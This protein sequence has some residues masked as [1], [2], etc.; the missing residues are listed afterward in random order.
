MSRKSTRRALSNTTPPT[1]TLALAPAPQAV[2]P[3]RPVVIERP[4]LSSS[5]GKALQPV[6]PARITSMLR[7]LDLGYFDDFADIVEQAH[8]DAIFRR[9]SYVRRAAVAARPY[10]VSP[11][12]DVAPE[13]RGAAD[14]L[15]GMTR[16]M[17]ANVDQLQAR[18]MEILEAIGHGVDVHE[19]TYERKHGLTLP[20]L[21]EKSHVATRDL[22]ID[23][24]WIWRARDAK[25]QWHTIDGGT[26]CTA[27]HADKT[28][29]GKPH[30]DTFLV[31]RPSMQG[32]K[33]QFGGEYLAALWPWL[34]KLKG[35]TFWLSGAERFGNPL[36]IL[37]AAKDTSQSQAD[38]LLADL[39][40][41]TADSV[42]VLKGETTLTIHSPQ[43][44]GSTTVFQ[45][46]IDNADRQVLI[47]M[48]VPP[49][50]VIASV[51]GSRSALDTRDG[52]RTEGSK[53]DDAAMW[54][55]WVRGPVT[56]LRRYNMRREDVPLPVIASQFD[57]A[58]P[59]PADILATGIVKRNQ[60]LASAGLPALGDDEGGDRFYVPNI[61][62]TPALPGAGY[63]PNA[64]P[65]GVKVAD[66]AMNGA[67]G[68]TLTDIVI[69]VAAGVLP[70]DAGI[71][72]MMTIF[73]ISLEEATR[74]MG[75][76]GAGFVPA[77]PA[78]GTP[79]IAPATPPPSAAP[80]APAPIATSAP[81]AGSA[82]AASP[83]PPSTPSAGGMP[84]LLS[85]R[86]PTS[87]TSSLSPTSP[88]RFARVPSSGG[89]TS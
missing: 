61:I 51:N 49:D 59:I 76:A 22:W 43:A 50:L 87:P 73:Q 10:T 80:I 42:G 30:T 62:T 23:R 40:Q 4:P 53:F 45:T 8:R 39:Q 11:P 69:K 46:L 57:D 84:D 35:W 12:D 31:H 64:A 56:W 19:C 1:T 82:P 52:L 24:D 3:M 65:D 81:S 54:G 72:N 86:T 20:T 71:A 32:G 37:Q 27:Q 74:N 47:A 78:S 13:M 48:G 7:R 15:A 83:F 85:S 36:M 75:S 21:T 58:L 89:P 68:Q 5:M 38:D 79:A 17:L 25:L 9:G 26:P 34:F 41:A 28:Q 33:P 88:R 66:A 63:D 70:R 16:E 2:Q 55:S 44:T 14:D 18:N 6:T 67:Q 77:D 60:I 29:D